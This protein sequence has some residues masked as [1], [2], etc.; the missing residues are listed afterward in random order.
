[1]HSDR[2]R[3]H[4]SVAGSAIFISDCSLGCLSVSASVA[5][6]L[7]ND[8]LEP[9][10]RPTVVH[11]SRSC[12]GRPA[13][14]FRRY[15]ATVIEVVRTFRVI[16]HGILSPVPSAD[17]PRARG[18]YTAR[19]VR[20]TTPAEAGLAAIGLVQADSRVAEIAVEWG[21]AAPDLV[22]DEV[23]DLAAAPMDDAP[24]GFIFYNEAD[25]ALA[26]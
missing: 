4:A 15:T 16:V 13:A 5:L 10:G 9:T 8:S 21:A 24:Q 1:M 25:D 2:S 17:G 26:E 23:I 20:A 3:T 19:E 22:V 14:Q 7:A 12:P 18:F 6:W 11:L